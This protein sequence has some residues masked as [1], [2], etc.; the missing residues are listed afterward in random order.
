[1]AEHALTTPTQTASRRQE[2]GAF[3]VPASLRPNAPAKAAAAIPKVICWKPGVSRASVTQISDSAVAP[4]LP[5]VRRAEEPKPR[6]LADA[7]L[8]A[9]NSYFRRVLV[10]VLPIDKLDDLYLP[11]DQVGRPDEPS[12]DLSAFLPPGYVPP[13]PRRSSPPSYWRARNPVQVQVQQPG[14][15]AKPSLRFGGKLL[16]AVCHN[17]AVHHYRVVD[18]SGELFLVPPYWVVGTP[19]TMLSLADGVMSGAGA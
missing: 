10:D 19:P 15:E 4:R 17:G 8:L 2:G 3:A 7:E 13:S 16:G 9:K 14:N 1:M 12:S 11:P 6:R 5:V 18:P